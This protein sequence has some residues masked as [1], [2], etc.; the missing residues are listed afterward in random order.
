MTTTKR[1]SIHH[2]SWLLCAAVFLAWVPNAAQAGGYATALKGVQ[3][4]DAV[5][6]V[7]QGNPK[8]ANVVFW[9]VKDSYA[10]PEV[11]SLSKAPN[12]VVVFHGPA[13]KLISS[14]K[15][16]FNGAEWAEVETFQ[17]TLRQMKKDGVRM[18][19][20]LYA[21][22]VMGVDASTI[23]PEVDHVDNGFVSVVGYQM[24]G[25]AVVRIP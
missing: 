16:L 8:V 1:L 17:E 9:A 15:A 24:Q 20:C 18:E 13:V 2:L 7:T 12:I 23:I 3:G 25:Y 6:E 4:F 10:G 5:Y 11:K 19:V 14:D 22:K 21:A